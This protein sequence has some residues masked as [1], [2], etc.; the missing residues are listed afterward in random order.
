[1]QTNSEKD[2]LS[3]QCRISKIQYKNLSMRQRKSSFNKGPIKN[4]LFSSN[5]LQI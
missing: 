1:M 5:N 4:K 2:H 3:E